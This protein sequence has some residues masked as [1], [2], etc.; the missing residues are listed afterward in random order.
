MILQ[1]HTPAAFL[2]DIL[3]AL[4]GMEVLLVREDEFRLWMIEQGTMGKR[5][6]IDA[7]S[8]CRRLMNCLHIE[9]DE[10]Y[11]KDGGKKLISLLEY[12]AEDERLGNPAPS[13]IDFGKGA[14]IKN[15]MAS[16]R[17]AARKYFE[18]CRSTAI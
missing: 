10:E 8:R 17:G 11:K 16:L 9:L 3:K 2:C 14:N 13:G 18:F 7:I 15:G 5:P 12:T 4:N 1:N 6:M